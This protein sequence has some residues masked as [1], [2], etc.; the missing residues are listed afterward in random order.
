[1]IQVQEQFIFKVFKAKILHVL[2]G[3][4]NKNLWLDFPTTTG[5][6]NHSLHI[7]FAKK[8]IS[9]VLRNG[10]LISLCRS[11]NL[12]CLIFTKI[13]PFV[14]SWDFS[15][16]QH[17]SIECKTHYNYYTTSYHFPAIFKV[18]STKL[19]DIGSLFSRFLTI[20]P[21]CPSSPWT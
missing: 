8:I 13:E 5:K 1:M 7:F 18:V 11:C 4:L 9:W 10:Y 16:F 17:I 2:Y 3:T 12:I 19:F 6:K 15:C 14:P 20:I 21:L